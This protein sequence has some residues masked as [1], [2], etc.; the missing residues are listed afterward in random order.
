MMRE[1]LVIGSNDKDRV[2]LIHTDGHAMVVYKFD[3]KN[4]QWVARVIP[5]VDDAWVAIITIRST[6]DD[7]VVLTR[8]DWHYE[9]GT[10]TREREKTVKVC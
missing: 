1:L 7:G 8:E 2:K 10:W 3:L 4:G 9:N 6:N 5:I